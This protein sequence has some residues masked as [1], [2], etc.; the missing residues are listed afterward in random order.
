MLSVNLL[1]LSIQG[2]EGRH[3]T[4]QKQT[5]S[6]ENCLLLLFVEQ[7]YNVYLN[8]VSFFVPRK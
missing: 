2:Y 1:A 7:G 4:S 3:P 6:K 5:V 8:T